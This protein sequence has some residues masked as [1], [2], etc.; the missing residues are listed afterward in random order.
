MQLQRVSLLGLKPVPLATS[1]R[2]V[3]SVPGTCA[4]LVSLWAFSEIHRHWKVSDKILCIICSGMYMEKWNGLR[5]TPGTWAFSWF[6]QLSGDLMISF[7]QGLRCSSQ[8]QR[9]SNAHPFHKCLD[10]NCKSECRKAYWKVAYSG[11][12]SQGLHLG[13]EAGFWCSRSFITLCQSNLTDLVD[14]DR[15]IPDV[16]ILALISLALISAWWLRFESLWRHG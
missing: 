15:L 7:C 10:L 12:R 8:V 5:M 6:I 9:C 16:S 2:M 1:A 14:Y 3:K 13:Y 4:D 11:R